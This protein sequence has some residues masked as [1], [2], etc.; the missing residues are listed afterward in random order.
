MKKDI[1]FLI[2]FCLGLYLLVSNFGCA[3]GHKTGATKTVT[4]VGAASVVKP[5]EATA[6]VNGEE[7][8]Q[9]EVECPETGDCHIELTVPINEAVVISLK[10]S[11]SGRDK[12]PTWVKYFALPAA[13][14]AAGAGYFGMKYP[15]EF[16]E[17]DGTVFYSG[18]SRGALVG[19]ASGVAL[20]LIVDLLDD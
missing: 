17:E 7:V 3:A 8:H 11:D 14:A 2:F 4:G 12:V 1:I 9:T 18:T 16:N 6:S 10:D 13:G 19:A 5:A 15:N 20:G